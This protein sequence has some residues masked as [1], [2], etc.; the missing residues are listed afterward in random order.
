MVSGTYAQV[1]TA[2]PIGAPTP[3]E[4]A[5]EQSRSEAEM[6]ARRR[7][8]TMEAIL[9]RAVSFGADQ[10]IVQ[11]RDIMGGDQPRLNGAPRVRGFRL[12]G[13]G[14]VFDVDVPSLQ[15]PILWPVRFLVDDARAAG[16]MLAELR[17][18][19]RQ[20][21]NPADR[22]EFERLIAKLET[23]APPAPNVDRLRQSVAAT[24]VAPEA[25]RREA[26][27][28]PPIEDPQAEYRKQVKAALIDAVLEN[29]ASVQVGA[30]EWLAIAAG[31]NIARDP[32][33][34]GDTVGS[35]TWVARI[36]GNVLADLRAQRI[37]AAEARALVEQGEQ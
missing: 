7:V 31:S 17:L 19:A 13:Y 2:G 26:P 4:P 6:L 18:F 27:P 37:T 22:A 11:V 1:P 21:E 3:A 12:P 30:D 32:L 23:Q 10:I 29:P 28:R 36:K 14:M 5:E 16:A 33:Y 8:E 20:M 24:S 9:E 15:V 35:T 25:S 34:P